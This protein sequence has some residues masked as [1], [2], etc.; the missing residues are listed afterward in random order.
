MYIKYR[1]NHP[2]IHQWQP[3][4]DLP[5]DVPICH[6]PFWI[7]IFQFGTTQSGFTQLCNHL[8]QPILDL[9]RDIPTCPAWIWHPYW[10]DGPSPSFFRI[11]SPR[12]GRAYLDHQPASPLWCNGRTVC[13]RVGQHRLDGPPDVLQDQSSGS[14]GY[15]EVWM[16]HSLFLEK[17]LSTGIL[18]NWI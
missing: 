18:W 1:L 16:R 8:S 6:Y 5:R 7:G 9:P 17:S 2:Q 3:I 10:R 13:S 14:P 12:V 4:L 11:A 15:I